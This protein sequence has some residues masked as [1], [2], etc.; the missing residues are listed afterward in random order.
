MVRDATSGLQVIAIFKL[1]KGLLLMSVGIGAL[2]LMHRDVALLVEHWVNALRVDPD[3][4]YL[5]LLLTKLSGVTPKMLHALSAGTFFYAAL[6]LTEGI[7]LMLEKRW[8]EYLTVIATASLVP[9]EL[10]ELWRRVTLAKL[11]VLG[12]NLAI[13]L[14]LLKVL[15]SASS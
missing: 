8:A 4:R 3:N 2:T 14:Y 6:M 5:H 15:R 7:G 9:L 13:V 1:V 10:Y 12:I 11:T